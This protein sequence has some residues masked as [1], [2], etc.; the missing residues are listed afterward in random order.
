M[1]WLVILSVVCVFDTEAEIIKNIYIYLH[2][3]SPRSFILIIIHVFVFILLYFSTSVQ[4]YMLIFQLN[5]TSSSSISNEAVKFSIGI[6]FLF[7]C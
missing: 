3:I 4:C 1:E 6:W 7:V 5:S 2:M